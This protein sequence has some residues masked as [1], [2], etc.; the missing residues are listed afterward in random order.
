M[1]SALSDN[2]VRRYLLFAGVFLV[3]GCE[4]QSIERDSTLIF[5]AP[6]LVVELTEYKEEPNTSS[7]PRGHFLCVKL[8]NS[9]AKGFHAEFESLRQ[10]LETNDPLG[11]YEAIRLDAHPAVTNEAI[12]EVLEAAKRKSI[13]DFSIMSC[14]SYPI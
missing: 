12:V 7:R 2:P 8:T 1:K 9:S 3:V 4:V 11:G 14:D 10:L 13:S 6:N 5:V